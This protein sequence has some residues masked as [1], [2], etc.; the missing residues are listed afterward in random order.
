MIYNHISNMNHSVQALELIRAFAADSYSSCMLETILQIK[1]YVIRVNDK[2]FIDRA[3]NMYS[4]TTVA[5]HAVCDMVWKVIIVY[6]M[7]V[8][9]SNYKMITYD[10]PPLY[11][12]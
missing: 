3:K 9:H 7:D 10:G 8:Y 1:V 5:V 6:H 12:Y 11:S 4:R 2:E